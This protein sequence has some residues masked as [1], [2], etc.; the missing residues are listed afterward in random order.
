MQVPQP[1]VFIVRAQALELQA[2][3]QEGVQHA[4]QL[5]K[6]ADVRPSFAD[7]ECTAICEAAQ[8]VLP[9]RLLQ[10]QQVHTLSRLSHQTAMG[11]ANGSADAI[12]LC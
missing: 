10:A 12:C 4:V 5:Q 7:A 9:V 8:W 11:R 6:A 3:M 2:M 1:M